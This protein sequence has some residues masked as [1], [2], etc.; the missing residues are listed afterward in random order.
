MAAFNLLFGLFEAGD[1]HLVLEQIF[2]HLDLDSMLN[3]SLVD[4][5]CYR[6]MR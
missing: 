3:V 2:S 1:Y 6:H 4:K 5:M